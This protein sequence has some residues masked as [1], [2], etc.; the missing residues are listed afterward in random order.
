MRRLLHSAAAI[1][2][3]P[4]E[5]KK[6]HWS[7]D[8]GESDFILDEPIKLSDGT[9]ITKITYQNAVPDFSPYALAVT[10]S[11]LTLLWLN[12]GQR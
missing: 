10:L 2:Q 7:G 5:G 11:K 9:V 6:G 3:T 8:R 4:V 12:C 1:K